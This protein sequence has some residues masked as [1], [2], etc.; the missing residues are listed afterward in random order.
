MYRLGG[1]RRGG[2]GTDM[3]ALQQSRDTYIITKPHSISAI[4]VHST[5]TTTFLGWQ[6]TCKNLEHSH[7]HTKR[8][9]SKISRYWHLQ[10]FYT[11]TYMH[12]EA[13]WGSL[14]FPWV[15][16]RCFTIISLQLFFFL[17]IICRMIDD[18]FH[19]L[20]S[21]ESKFECNKKCNQDVYEAHEIH[22]Q[23]G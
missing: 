19:V 13:L 9:L 16:L 17:K 11:C 1:G 5:P 20:S 23:Y 8:D 22:A 12:L 3:T 4:R 7:A 18:D 2:G 15:I 10:I 21:F 6:I 14:I